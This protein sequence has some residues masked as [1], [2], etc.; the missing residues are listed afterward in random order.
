MP[1][2][3]FLWKLKFDS[4]PLLVQCEEEDERCQEAAAV[5]GRAETEFPVNF[6]IRPVTSI[7]VDQMLS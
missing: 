2:W 6:P 5:E 1:Y 4:L 7:S 3:N